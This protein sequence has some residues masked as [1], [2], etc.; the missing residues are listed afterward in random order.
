MRRD[1][2]T[3]PDCTRLSQGGLLSLLRRPR[4][5]ALFPYTT[6]FRSASCLLNAATSSV[7]TS[8]CQS[9][10]VRG[11]TAAAAEAGRSEEHTSELQALRHLVCRL[12]LE[13][14]KDADDKKERVDP[15]GLDCLAPLNLG[16]Q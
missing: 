16:E 12:L 4:R 15:M 8:A 7:S 9:A 14:K 3:A 6:L 13:K 1:G 5:S 2:R 11:I 10:L